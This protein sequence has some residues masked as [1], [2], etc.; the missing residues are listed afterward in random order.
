MLGKEKNSASTSKS[1]PALA[2]ISVGTTAVV[3]AEGSRKCITSNASIKLVAS[4]GILGP[5][6][7]TFLRCLSIHV[8]L[9]SISFNLLRAVILESSGM[10]LIK[11]PSDLPSLPI[12]SKLSRF[13][14]SP[15]RAIATLANLVS[16]LPLL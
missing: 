5:V 12:Y 3:P 2:T 10:S 4:V 6:I 16:F 15:L 9:R 1:D 8:S 7:V 13:T 14:K 11:V